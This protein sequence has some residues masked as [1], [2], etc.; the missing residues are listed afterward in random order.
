MKKVHI[1]PLPKSRHGIL[2][3][4]DR[5]A[6]QPNVLEVALRPDGIYVTRDVVSEDEPVVPVGS[7]EI[8]LPFLLQSIDLITHPFNPEEP[9]FL[10][11]YSAVSALLERGREPFAILVPGRA[12]FSAWL[13]LPK[14]VKKF[15]GYPVIPANPIETNNRVIVLGTPPNSIFVTSADVGVAVDL[16]V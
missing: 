11:L 9:A 15:F 16:G 8:D 10:A 2:T 4:I 5:A 14:V 13:G 12:V 6:F 1:E 3:Y 7:N